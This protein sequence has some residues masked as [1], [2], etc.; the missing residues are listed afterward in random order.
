MAKTEDAIEKI[1]NSST[2]KVLVKPNSKK[3]RVIGYDKAKK[4]YII[5]IKEPAEKNKANKE[6]IK[7]ISK[8]AKKNARIK[9]GLSSREKILIIGQ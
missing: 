5:E 8:T 9:S 2:I 1:K 7:L 3:T 6:L 4:A